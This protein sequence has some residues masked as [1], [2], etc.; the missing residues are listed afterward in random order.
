[1]KT[2][3]FSEVFE[4]GRRRRTGSVLPACSGRLRMSAPLLALDGIYERKEEQH[5]KKHIYHHAYKIHASD[6]YISRKE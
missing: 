1:M 6:L 4:R 2:W 5:L 3:E